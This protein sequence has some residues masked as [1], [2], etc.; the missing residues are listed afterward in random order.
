MENHA[1][2]SVEQ[3]DVAYPSGVESNID[4]ESGSLLPLEK[5]GVVEVRLWIAWSR[6]DVDRSI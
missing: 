6:S 5:V 4:S 1:S 2:V 3:I